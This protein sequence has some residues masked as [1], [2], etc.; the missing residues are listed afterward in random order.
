MKKTKLLLTAM[1]LMASVGPLSAAPKVPSE[2]DMA[3]YLLVY[4]KDETHSIHLALS[5][6][7]YSFTS[8]NDDKPI[9]DGKE[10]AEQKGLRDP[11]IMRGPDN[12]FYIAATDLHIFAQ[13]EGL[14]DTEWQR[15]GAKY[16]WGNNRALVLLKSDDLID[17]SHRTLR[18]DQAFDSLKDIGC[19]WAPAMNWDPEKKRIMIHF[20]MRY[21]NGKNRLYYSYMNPEFTALETEPKL[22]FKYPNDRVD[23][24]DSDITQVGKRFILAYTPQDPGPGVK[25]ASSDSL[26]SGYVYRDEWVPG[27]RSACEG[28][29]IW[30]RIGEDKW[31]IMFD[32]Y[33]ARPH[34][35]A[36][37]ETSDFEN[38][39][40]LGRFNRGV[41]K[42]TN[43]SLSKHGAV[44]PLTKAEAD[45]LAKHWGLKQY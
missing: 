9:I 16:S 36:F 4:F 27:E 39:T 11:Y 34:E 43:F 7:G 3:A 20:T 32:A 45:R 1:L 23:Y 37:T 29:S 5:S 40:F 19:V 44:I 6:D 12:K 41:M 30:K 25:I 22:L 38:F 8:L 10:V 42:A 26:T 13:R 31:V 18:V 2:K 21:G 24:I 33:T 14:R 28:P 35:L 17:W 15:D